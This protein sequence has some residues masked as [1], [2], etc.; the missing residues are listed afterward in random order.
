VFE[1]SDLSGLVVIVT[2]SGS[3]IGRSVVE[4]LLKENS[5]VVA[6]SRNPAKLARAYANESHDNLLRFIGDCS[7]P[8]ACAMMVESAIDKWGKVDILI[9]NAG[10]GFFGSILD[11]DD[12][13]VSRLVHNN[14]LGTIFPIRAAVPY[15]KNSKNPD[16]LIVSSAAG[17]R[18]FA[19][20]AVYAATKHAQVGLAGS[21]E[22][23]L[24]PLGIRVSLVNPAGVKTD[25]AIGKGREHNNLEMLNYMDPAEVAYVII[26]VLRMPRSVRTQNWNFWSIAQQ[27]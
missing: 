9:A 23:E 7:D 10:S 20:E 22:R 15:L 19:N 8:E 16:I 14:V 3:G 4:F 6:N 12:D 25:F 5:L 24:T 2:G 26:S 18:G 27:S 17:Y 13:E 11:H 21:L 1:L